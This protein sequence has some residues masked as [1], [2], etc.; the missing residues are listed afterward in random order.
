MEY[1]RM[2]L[3]KLEDDQLKQLAQLH[4]S[5]MHTLLA[6]IGLSMVLRY[7]QIARSDNSVVGICAL[8]SSKK[9]IG[10]AMGSPHPDRIN[11]ALRSPLLWFAFQMLRVLFTRPFIFFQLISSVLSS[12]AETE[13][14]GDG[15]ELTYIGVAADQR[16]KGLGNDLL[17][18]FIE[19]SRE[20]GYRSLILSVEKDNEAAIALYQK[21]GFKII[22]TFSEGRYER[23]RMELSLE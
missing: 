9:I 2:S 3:P 6:D 18:A 19:M 16:N 1:E 7:Y 15:I 11:S 21:A 23:H 17:N 8:D 20:A 13:M 22:K 10:W 14:K 12:S 4:Y 5:V